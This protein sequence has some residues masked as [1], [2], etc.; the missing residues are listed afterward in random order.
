MTLSAGSR[1]GIL[2]GGQLG[3]ML[4]MAAARLGFDTA[5]YCPHGEAPA[6]R[7]ASRHWQA[8]YD[9]VGA[10]RD[11]AAACDVVTV[12]FENV[13]A[14]AAECIEA[15]GTAFRP[16]AS[17]LAIAQDRAREKQFLQD[18]GIAVAPWHAVDGPGELASA[19]RAVNGRGVLK[20]RREGYDGKGQMRLHGGEDPGEVWQA[21]GARPCVLEAWVEFEME[22]SGLVA[23]GCDGEIASWEP[24]RNLHVDGMLRRAHVPSGLDA[25]MRAEVQS[26]VIAL[27]EALD[28]IGVLALEFFVLPGGR[29][30]ANEFAPRVH[31]SGHWTPEACMTGQ[32]EN[33]IRAISGW[34]LGETRRLLDVE[35]INIIGEEALR[36]PTDYDRSLALTLYGKGE[37]RPGRKMGHYVRRLGPAAL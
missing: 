1:I 8:S 24:S 32:F 4:A 3:R 11:F 25:R 22:V 14:G 21:M 12:E 28:F 23:R 2:G 9:D 19:I 7:V 17:A 6:V 33:H 35:M 18:A 30:L 26:A 37:A 10:L 5:I 16:G 29:L 27:A 13:P 15:I 34:P 20:T 31:N 36:L